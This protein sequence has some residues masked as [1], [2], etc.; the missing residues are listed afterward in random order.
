MKK[1]ILPLLVLTIFSCKRADQDYDA[2]G[3][4]EAD[5]IIVTAEATGKILELNLN[6]GDALK[7]NQNIGLIDGKG[8]ELQKEQVLASINAI[9][10][11]TNDAAP[12][13]AVLQSQLATQNSQIT[14]LQEQLN[15]A[16]RER[17]RTANLVKSDAATRKQLDD[18]NGNVVVIQK[19]IASAKSQSEILKQQ[20][21]STLEQVKIQ[22]RAILSEKNPTEKKV[23]QI[24]EQLKHNVIS[25]PIKGIVLTKYMNKG[26]F[27]TIGKPIY[28]MANLDEMTL[29]AYITGDQLAKVK[30]GQNVKILVDAGNG[31]T[32]EMNGKIYWISQKSEFT[33][34]TI[35]TKDERANLVYATKIHVKNDGFLKIGMYGEV[36]L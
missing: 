28:K 7:A 33:P 14:V 19:Q 35:Q 29:R 20:I 5:E 17:N 13:I 9:E 32:K 24:D 6:E 26:E 4:F 1:Y 18:L 36:K 12:Q 11:K 30:V 3:T 8:V 34:K 21:S 15:N 10:Q 23:L 25:S 2:S 16:V 22:N 27:A 31:E